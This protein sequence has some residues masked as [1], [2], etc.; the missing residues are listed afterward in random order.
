MVSDARRRRLELEASSIAVLAP[1]FYALSVWTALNWTILGTPFAWL[2]EETT[3]TFVYTRAVRPESFALPHVVAIVAGENLF[4]FPLLFVVAAALLA[5]AAKRRDPMALTLALLLLLNVATTVAIAAAT[6]TPHLYEPR[7]NIRTMPLVLV[8]VAWL[9]R[10]ATT[11]RLR[12]G[13]VLAAMAGLALTIPL[14]WHTMKTFR[15]QYDERV[16]VA[17][18]ETG[19]NQS[20]H[21]AGLDPR[22]DRGMAQYVLAHVQRGNAVLID[23][24]QTFGVVLDTGRP[25][26][27]SDRIDAGDASW[28][29]IAEHPYRK[30]P[31]VLISNIQ[32][33]LLRR[34]YPRP[35]KGF[36]LV[37]ATR[38][39]RLYRVVGPVG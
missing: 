13:I 5:L 19:R 14:T 10:E 34:M 6:R 20:H 25:E 37:Y 23:D 21:L 12:N 3:Q 4:L 29:Q 26:L 35:G 15:Y 8:G 28:L 32:F 27:F 1:V 39:S 38:T 33:D 36:R 16:V 11:A 22:A 30:V 2:H 7:F 31:Y 9:Y 24:A 17:G 18:L